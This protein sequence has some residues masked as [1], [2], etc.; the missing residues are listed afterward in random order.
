[1]LLA[2]GLTAETIP[3][4]APGTPLDA[5]L[6]EHRM[7]IEARLAAGF[8]EVIGGM[9]FATVAQ[10]YNGQEL[11][12][13]ARLGR[14]GLAPLTRVDYNER[15][16]SKHPTWPTG[17]VVPDEVSLPI[18]APSVVE[19]D[20]SFGIAI[21]FDGRLSAMSDAYVPEAWE[22]EAEIMIQNLQGY[23]SRPGGEPLPRSD[24]PFY[25]GVNFRTTLVHAWGVVAREVGARTIGIRSAGQNRWVGKLGLRLADKNP[26]D[27]HPYLPVQFYR[28]LGTKAMLPGYD[29]VAQDLG[30][31]PMA[32]GHW[33]SVLPIGKGFPEGEEI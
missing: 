3:A 23:A 21:T 29:G 27:G 14:F 5:T 2:P 12:N 33:E 30:F 19:M 9:E 7:H 22:D 13:A 32:A 26:P 25:S 8:V 18:G 11:P 4:T 1:M 6:H 31:T 24:N 10:P 15:P 28:D 17:L 16:D 20:A